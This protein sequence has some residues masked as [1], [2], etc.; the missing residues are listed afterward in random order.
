MV[1]EWVATGAL[2]FHPPPA[3]VFAEHI[4]S[5]LRP[6]GSEHQPGAVI[7]HDKYFSIDLML[8]AY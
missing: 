8:F 1:L 5:S 6:S 7:R 3:R 2:Q 4:L